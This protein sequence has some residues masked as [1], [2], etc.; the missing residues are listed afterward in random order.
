MPHS[1]LPHR[2]AMDRSPS[3]PRYRQYVTVT[4]C[5]TPSALP[6]SPVTCIRVTLLGS[7]HRK[8]CHDTEITR[9]RGRC[10]GDS[11]WR[12]KVCRPGGFTGDS[13]RA[14]SV[15]AAGTTIGCAHVPG[16]WDAIG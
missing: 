1:G 10:S 14:V 6:V 9:N 8:A 2:P 11:L 4:N 13:S 5:P 3:C 12:G 15:V 16:L 7:R